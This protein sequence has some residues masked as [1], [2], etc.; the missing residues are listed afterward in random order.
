MSDKRYVSQ[1]PVPPDEADQVVEDAPG[2]RPPESA[3]PGSAE[4][5]RRDVTQKADPDTGQTTDD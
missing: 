3:V 2:R 1:A 5:N 4:A